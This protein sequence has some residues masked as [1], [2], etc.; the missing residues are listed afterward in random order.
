MINVIFFTIMYTFS[1]TK[2]GGY[3]ETFETDRVHRHT[4]AN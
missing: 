2:D 1:K 3:G 4:Q